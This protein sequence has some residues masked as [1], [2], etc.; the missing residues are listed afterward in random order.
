M[1]DKIVNKI[2]KCGVLAASSSEIR[3]A[4]KDENIQKLICDI[5]NSP[6]PE[7]VSN[8]CVVIKYFLL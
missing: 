1:T 8:L 4:L 3:D 7:N 2:S 6:D 5:D